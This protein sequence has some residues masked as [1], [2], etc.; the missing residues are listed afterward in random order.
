MAIVF[1]ETIYN[2][3]DMNSFK[4]YKPSSKKSLI[5]ITESQFRRLIGSVINE[6][7]SV[8]VDLSKKSFIPDSSVPIKN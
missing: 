3:I 5:M 1:I 4:N 7:K 8:N 2:K 6:S